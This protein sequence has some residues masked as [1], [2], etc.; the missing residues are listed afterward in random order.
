[1]TYTLIG[2]GRTA[3][4]FLYDDA[5]VLKLYKSSMP[6]GSIDNEFSM[7]LYAY[8]KGL[9]T[10]RPVSR[11]RK[12]HRHGIVFD[13]IQGTS[14]LNILS[15]DP[16]NMPHLAKKM[17]ELHH[18][19][20]AVPYPGAADS[21]KVSLV[22]AIACTPLLSEDDKTR[23]VNYIAALPDGNFLCHGDFHPDNILIDDDLRIIDWM[24]GTA[25]NPACDVARSKMI[26]ECS[27]LPDS[28]TA[29]MRFF[30]ALGKKALA[31]KYVKEYCRIS[32][33]SAREI[34]E[35]MLPLYAARL[36]ENLSGKETSLLLKRIKKEIRK[37]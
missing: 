13:R 31:K 17:A 24:T 1:M 29:V 34:D 23:I 14:L 11:I 32:G 9:P 37:A 26:L 30:L 10:P 4:V 35:W 2:S 21:Q 12:D 18:R 33:L 16:M 3:D 6:D 5:F 8:E 28:I 15:D 25:G 20:N 36:T 7:A 27:G 19:I 22:R